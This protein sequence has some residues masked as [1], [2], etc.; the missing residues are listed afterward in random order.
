MESPKILIV[1][2]DKVTATL[3][4]ATLKK[5]G[6]TVTAVVPSGEEA[7]HAI[8]ENHPDLI[9]MDINLQGEK[10]GI[11]TVIEIHEKDSMPVIFLTG[12]SDEITTLRAIDADPFGYIVK[13]Y[14]E[15]I[16]FITIKMALA[17]DSI[18][19]KLIANETKYR[20]LFHKSRDAVFIINPMGQ[21]IDFNNSTLE[22]LGYS[23]EEMKVLSL[24]NLFIDNNNLAKVQHQIREDGYLKDHAI[25]LQKK[26]NSFINCLVSV[27]TLTT[28]NNEITEF[29]GI[30]KD[31]TDLTIPE[32][33]QPRKKRAC[34]TG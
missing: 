20:S 23:E 3:I 30:I 4:E 2:D 17:R 27:N 29:Q 28:K 34:N 1:E 33:P 24:K 15:T 25:W 18:E 16:L 13:P 9:L 6:Y 11:T 21:F 32:K 19:K 12:Y 8:I 10:D 31:I 26:D 7:I 14:Y 22:L 5:I